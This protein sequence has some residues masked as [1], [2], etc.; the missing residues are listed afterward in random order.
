MKQDALSSWEAEHAGPLAALTVPPALEQ[1]QRELTGGLLEVAE[2]RPLA[3]LAQL[4]R[5]REWCD[6]QGDQAAR[7]AREQG[8]GWAEVGRAAGLSAQGAQQRWGKA[9]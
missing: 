2:D 6:R 1:L 7:R 5:L 9:G 8:A 3:A 4:R